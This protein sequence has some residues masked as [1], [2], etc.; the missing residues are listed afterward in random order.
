MVGVIKEGKKEKE[1]VKE[2]ERV[3]ISFPI[4]FL[5]NIIGNINL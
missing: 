1:K 4:E 3:N 2:I 5:L